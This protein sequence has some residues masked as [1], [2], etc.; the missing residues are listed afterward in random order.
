[1]IP[2]HLETLLWRGAQC[3]YDTV[4]FTNYKQ[5]ANQAVA[6]A[7]GTTDILG[8]GLEWIPIIGGMQVLAHHGPQFHSRIL[9]VSYLSRQF[10]IV[11]STN[12][13]G[14]AGCFLHKPGTSETAFKDLCIDGL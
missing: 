12:F 8:L 4:L 13:C 14:Y 6:A 3:F 9:A 2:S 11:V 5:I 7:F 10:N 1:M